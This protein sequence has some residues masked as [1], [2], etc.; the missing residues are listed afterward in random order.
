MLRGAGGA[1]RA[2][3]VLCW[4]ARALVM[5]RFRPP[6]HV[7]PTTAPTTAPTS[8]LLLLLLLLR[9]VRDIGRHILQL[10]YNSTKVQL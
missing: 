10:S 6:T 4:A 9:V 3:V 1:A 5:L 2:H 7:A 8:L